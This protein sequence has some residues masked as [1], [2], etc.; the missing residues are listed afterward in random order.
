MHLMGVAGD[1]QADRLRGRHIPEPD[2]VSAGVEVPGQDPD[3]SPHARAGQRPQTRS[4][5]LAEL[6]PHQA[7][8]AR[9]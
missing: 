1:G 3:R 6:V 7:M 9:P 2:P 5:D 4:S 8:F